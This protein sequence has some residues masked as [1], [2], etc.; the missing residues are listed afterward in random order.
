MSV[1]VRVEVGCVSDDGE[2]VVLEATDA[3]HLLVRLRGK[4][5]TLARSGPEVD[6][7]ELLRAISTV[8]AAAGWDRVEVDEADGDE[9]TPSRRRGTAAAAEGVS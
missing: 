3:G 8:A 2:A 1:S 6:A 4:R 9:P 5:G 7:S